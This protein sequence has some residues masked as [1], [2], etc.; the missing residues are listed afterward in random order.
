MRRRLLMISKNLENRIIYY[1]AT[2]KVEP[3]ATHVFGANIVSNEWDSATG[4][5]VI[6]F[7]ADVTEI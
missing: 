6:T 1:T 5:G 4:Q 2:A 7:D 3:N